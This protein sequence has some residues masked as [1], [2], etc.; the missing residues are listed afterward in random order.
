MADPNEPVEPWLLAIDSWIKKVR[1]KRVAAGARMKAGPKATDGRAAGGPAATVPVWKKLTPRTWGTVAVTVVIVSFIAAPVIGTAIRNGQEQS[2]AAAL[3]RE[4]EE[5]RQLN[6]AAEKKQDEEEERQTEKDE[7][8]ALA[9]APDKIVEID[10]AIASSPWAA[11]ED[12]ATL[13]TAKDELQKAIDR[14]DGAAVRKVLI[15]L[16]AVSSILGSPEQAQDKVFFQAMKAAGRSDV[17]PAAVYWQ[18]QTVKMRQWCTDTTAQW[19][20]QRPAAAEK[21]RGF[22]S[23]LDA[24][25]AAYC[26][27]LAGSKQAA[28]AMIGD[29]KRAVGTS[30]AAGVWRTLGPASDCYWERSTGGGDIIDNSFISHAPDGVTVEVFAGE[31]FTIQGCGLWEKIG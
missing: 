21:L 31:G 1:A 27:D 16:P 3:E 22:D 2:A 23:S 14:K 12:V 15:G 11:T 7:K 8:Q 17:D 19:Q 13:T 29:G 28:A 30:V 25:I 18:E 6:D 5:Q 4:A 26:P 24:A 20:N 10:E 9:D